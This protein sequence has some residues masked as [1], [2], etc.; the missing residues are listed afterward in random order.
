MIETGNATFSY[1][2]RQQPDSI[3]SFKLAEEQAKTNYRGMWDC[4]ELVDTKVLTSE[5][6]ILKNLFP[7]DINTATIEELSLVP[8][9]GPKTAETIIQYREEKGVFS[10]LDDL[11]ESE[12]LERLLWKN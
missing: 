2:G 11:L 8:S 7:L 1:Y 6:T 3:L 4:P 12:E 9:V 10:S 5:A